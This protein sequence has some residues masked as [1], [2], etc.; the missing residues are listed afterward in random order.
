VPD[1][2]TE[3][4]EACGSVAGVSSHVRVNTDA[5]PGYAPSLEG[6]CHTTEVVREPS[7][8][9]RDVHLHSGTREQL[10][11][12]WL[13]LD[14]INFGS[15]WFPTLR[16]PRGHSGYET[17][18]SGLRDRFEREGAWSAEELVAIQSSELA[19]VFAQDPGHEL[20]HLFAS[21]LRDLGRHVGEDHAGSFA[22]VL[23]TAGQSAP[24][25]VQELAE[26]QCFNDVSFYDGLR[27]PFLKRAQIAAADVHRAELVAFADLDRL[28]MFADNLVPHVLRLDGVLQFERALVQRIERGELIEHGSPEEI[29][30]R[31]CA[32]HAVELLTASLPG[33]TA[34]EIDQQLWLR[35][36]GARYKAV[37][38]HRCRC[39]AY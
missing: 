29:A 17:I 6:F 30:I 21:S 26:W 5:I 1:H 24:R 19:T 4:R 10:A 28:T 23:D 13:T 12:Y 2:L 39:T 7:G 34:A 22:A 37:R 16:K 11:A 27:L 20:I 33:A 31:A 25:L 9:D 18:A 8:P 14:A 35:G 3:L 32:V 15:G 38:R 36:R